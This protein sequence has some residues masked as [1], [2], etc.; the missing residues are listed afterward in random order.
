MSIGMRKD[1]NKKILFILNVASRVNSFSYTS[2][3]AAKTQNMDFHIAGNWGYVSDEQRK[4]DERKYGIHI[5]QIDFVRKPY[6]L[7][8]YN[9]YKQLCNVIHENCIDYIHCNTPI[10][11]LCGRIAGRKYK[12][13]KVIYQVHGFH[14]YKGAPLLNKLIYYPIE[15]FLAKYTDALITINHEDFKAAQKLKLRNNGKVYYVHGVGVDTSEYVNIEVDKAKKRKDINVDKDDF[16][17]VSVGRLDSNKNNKTVIKAVAKA[18]NPK[19]KFILCGDGDE[20]EELKQLADEFGVGRQVVFLGNR[21]DVKEIYSVADC[22]VIAS[23]REGLSRSLME[24][25]ASGLPCIVSDIRGNVDLI[26]NKV[27]GYVC[28]VSDY[29]AFA[30]AINNLSTNVRLCKKMSELNIEK[31]QEYSVSVV[32]KE[33]QEIYSKVFE[34]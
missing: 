10:G 4:D 16:V 11:G 9:A 6:N 33:M 20:R 13:E 15:R 1:M 19:I 2:M 29:K 23:F 22:F 21:T 14:F 25:M 26:E 17:V 12:L 5:H 28:K 7:Q 32:E 3:L 27:N 24:A 8:N 31:V 34:Y 18:N 30:D